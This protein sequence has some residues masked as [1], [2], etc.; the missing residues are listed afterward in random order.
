VRPA[1]EPPEVR[2]RGRDDVRLL[3]AGPDGTTEATFRDLPRFLR[4]GDLLVVNDSATLP[5]AVDGIRDREPVTVH[6]AT[7]LDDGAWVVEVRPAA[8]DATGPLPGARAGDRVDLPAGAGLTL[9]A[10]YPGPTARH[11]RL[12]RGTVAVEAPVERYLERHGRPISYAYV[13]RRWPLTA[14]Q[15]VF[16]TKPGSAEMPSAARPFTTELVTRLVTYGVAVAPV[17]LHTGV[18]SQQAGEPPLPE[19]FEVPATTTALVEHTRRRGRRVI[20]VGTT[21]TRALET[22]TSGGWTDL[23]LGPERPARVVDGIVSGW[24]DRGASHLR[25]LEAVAGRAV[26]AAAYERAEALG[27]LMHEFGDS[28]LLLRG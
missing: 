5:A 4:P 11:S 3:V 10:A 26:V 16:A 12:W 25:L 14:Y 6:F 13:P 1:T 17:T 19:R 18:S 21:V 2:G 27:Y 22:G 20:A 24:H 28:A 9:D 15:T 8:P 23:V 7:A